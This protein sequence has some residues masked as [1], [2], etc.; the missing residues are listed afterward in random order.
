MQWQDPSSDG[1]NSSVSKTE[2]SKLFP[3]AKALIN[4]DEI[5][6]LSQLSK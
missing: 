4:E 1:L 3:E 2:I 5:D 6:K